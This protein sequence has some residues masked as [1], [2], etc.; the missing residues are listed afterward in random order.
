MQSSRDFFEICL[1]Y[2]ELE[3]KLVPSCELILYRAFHSDVP[4]PVSGEF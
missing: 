2:L 4:L 1:V 3:M